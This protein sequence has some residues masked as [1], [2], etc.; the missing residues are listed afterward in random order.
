MF[1]RSPRIICLIAAGWAAA[2][3]TS[4]A[5]A[6]SP[7][8]P[9]AERVDPTVGDVGPLAQSLR[10]VPIDLRA[11]TGFDT[12]FRLSGPARGGEALLGRI[13]GGV[14]AV[15]SRSVYEPSRFGDV[16]AIP[17]GTQFVI[18]EPPAWLLDQHD[19]AGRAA[20]GRAN[21]IVR[22][23][24]TLRLNP[25]AQPSA[26]WSPALQRVAPMGSRATSVGTLLRRAVAA[27]RGGA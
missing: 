12:V 13:D 19:S 11:P 7:S 22:Q 6:Q 23:P 27:Q 4:G 3:V 8:W 26:A 14:T 25:L 2:A 9:A 21:P 20:L 1:H 18:G 5:G 16:A 10:L 15:F 24:L 17:P